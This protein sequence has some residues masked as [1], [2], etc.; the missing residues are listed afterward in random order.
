[1]KHDSPLIA[2]LVAKRALNTR[3]TLND[4]NIT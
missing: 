2:H 1:M 4:R 3:Y